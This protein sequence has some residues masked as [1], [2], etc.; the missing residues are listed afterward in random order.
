MRVKGRRA[1]FW[2]SLISRLGFDVQLA[3]AFLAVSDSLRRF[4]GGFAFLFERPHADPRQL[5][6]SRLLLVLG[7]GVFAGFWFPL[8]NLCSSFT[9][10]L[11]R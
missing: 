8:L 3:A 10:V 11:E 2:W 9:R 4:S 7:C 5:L 1:C 6:G